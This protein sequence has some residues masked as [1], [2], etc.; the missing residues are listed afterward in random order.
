MID[1]LLQDSRALGSETLSKQ[2]RSRAINF[3]HLCEAY[4]HAVSRR[5]AREGL[6]RRYG[7]LSRWGTACKSGARDSSLNAQGDRGRTHLSDG[8]VLRGIPAGAVP[9]FVTVRRASD[10]RPERPTKGVSASKVLARLA[11]ANRNLP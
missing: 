11:G 2:T 7:T 5:A 9:T 4:A 3:V 8:P 10:C 1:P 6:A